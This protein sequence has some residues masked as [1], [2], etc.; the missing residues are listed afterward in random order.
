MPLTCMPNSGHNY[1]CCTIPTHYHFMTHDILALSIESL[2][3]SWNA[4]SSHS[5]TNF[6]PHFKFDYDIFSY[7]VKHLHSVY[8]FGF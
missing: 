1:F 8:V 5:T 2:C 4:S 3:N 6:A 7:V